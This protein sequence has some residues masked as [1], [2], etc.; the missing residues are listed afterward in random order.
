MTIADILT[1]ARRGSEHVTALCAGMTA[2]ELRALILDCEE[3]VS[4]IVKAWGED[5]PEMVPVLRAVHPA[6]GALETELA[7]RTRPTTPERMTC[8]KLRSILGVSITRLNAAVVSGAPL[9]ARC[10]T[11]SAG[12]SFMCPCSRA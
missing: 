12:T 11:S 1:A 3:S 5:D 2:E 6:R 7:R 9:A 8:T 4:A 10:A